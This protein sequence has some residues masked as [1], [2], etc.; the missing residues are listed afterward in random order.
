M[1]R[2][3][4]KKKHPSENTLTLTSSA[5]ESSATAGSERVSSYGPY[6]V[7]ARAIETL[8]ALYRGL[9]IALLLTPSRESARYAHKS[10]PL[11]STCAA[12]FEN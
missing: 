11:A 2:C 7:S 12:G 8:S 4:D 3:S 6:G 10:V 9:P 1:P 5:A